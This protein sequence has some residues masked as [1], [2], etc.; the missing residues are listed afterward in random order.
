MERNQKLANIDSKLIYGVV[1]TLDCAH[2][3][4]QIQEANEYL[5][6]W[7]VT[8]DEAYNELLALGVI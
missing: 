6:K 2:E 7:D 8:R 3:H 4:D 5:V 1:A